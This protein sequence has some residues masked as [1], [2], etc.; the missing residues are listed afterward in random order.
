MPLFSAGEGVAGLRFMKSKFSK[1]AQSLADS[2]H[3]KHK[4]AIMTGGVLIIGAVFIF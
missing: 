1:H 3:G 4:E 2:I